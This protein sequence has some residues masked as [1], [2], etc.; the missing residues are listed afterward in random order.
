MND[1][2]SR[3]RPPGGVVPPAEMRKGRPDAHR[4]SSDLVWKEFP[5]LSP[6]S[7]GVLPPESV[8]CGCGSAEAEGQ[9]PGVAPR[10]STW[11]AIALAYDVR[12]TKELESYQA[13]SALSETLKALAAATAD[14]DVLL[15]RKA[16][17]RVR[18]AQARALGAWRAWRAARD[19]VRQLRRGDL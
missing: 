16:R 1:K 18:R 11:R 2:V 17:L 4:G 9:G 7:Q 19:H 13:E 6:S 5:T 8:P 14:G 12:E 15:I 10:D 3:S